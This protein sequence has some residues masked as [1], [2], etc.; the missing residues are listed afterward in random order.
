MGIR[1]LAD[2]LRLY[3]S[4]EPS[5]LHTRRIHRLSYFARRE[6]HRRGGGWLDIPTRLRGRLVT[7]PIG[8]SC[9]SLSRPLERDV[10]LSAELEYCL[11]LAFHQAHTAR[12]EFITVE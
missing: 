9:Q 10:V 5:S 3:G 12:H 4:R 11:N 2:R 6:N 8:C 7:G 1:F